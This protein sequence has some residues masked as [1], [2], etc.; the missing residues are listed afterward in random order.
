[1]KRGKQTKKKDIEM[2]AIFCYYSTLMVVVVG[3]C[4]I[5]ARPFG[6]RQFGAPFQEFR[7]KDSSVASLFQLEDL[8]D[9]RFLSLSNLPDSLAINR[10]LQDCQKGSVSRVKR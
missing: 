6:I 1:M 3:A 9:R 10:L 2:T 8:N 5:A 4:I 7:R